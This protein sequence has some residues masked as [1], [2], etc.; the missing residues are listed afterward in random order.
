MVETK[1]DALTIREIERL[2]RSAVMPRFINPRL[3]DGQPGDDI[4]VDT[5]DRGQLRFRVP[6]PPVTR[7]A[8]TLTEFVNV[9]TRLAEDDEDPTF[10]E[11]IEIWV[12]PVGERGNVVVCAYSKPNKDDVRAPKV[13]VSLPCTAAWETLKSIDRREG[14]ALNQR[15]LIKL[16]TRELHGH[17]DIGA[18][19]L[20]A[21]RTIKWSAM[22]NLGSVIAE[23]SESIVNDHQRDVKFGLG[24]VPDSFVV[25]SP[26]V[27]CAEVDTARSVP[28]FLDVHV[29]DQ[30]FYLRSAPEAV[31]EKELIALRFIADWVHDNLSKF[32]IPCNIGEYDQ[33]YA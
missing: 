5:P 21:I 17:V 32:D 8:A 28:V 24:G 31:F 18:D 29:R 22:E 7:E 12:S 19:L 15:E 9:V 10:A 6:F 26:V 14:V 3:L 2:V 16:L 33:A 1:S 23:G 4:I 27:V 13:R 30:E 20:G 25:N 11:S